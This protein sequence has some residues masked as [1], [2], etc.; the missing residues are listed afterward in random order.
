MRGA[1]AY[2]AVGRGRAARSHR[3]CGAD[4]T[5]W[6]HGAVWRGRRYGADGGRGHSGAD[7]AHGRYRS[8]GSGRGHHVRADGAH[9]DGLFRKGDYL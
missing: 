7:R 4:W 3:A 8:D 5:H 6:T 2:G 9:R 1:G